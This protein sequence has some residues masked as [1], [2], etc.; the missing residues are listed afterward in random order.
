VE[1]LEEMMRLELQLDILDQPI[2]DHQRAKKRRLRLDI[3]GE[4]GLLGRRFAALIDSDYFGHGIE[5]IPNGRLPPSYRCRFSWR[6]L[7]K[8]TLSLRGAGGDV[9]IQQL[10]C[11]AALAMTIDGFPSRG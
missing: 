1:R 2:V 11:F 5:S 3:L 9:A 10:D 7:W 6:A 4:L 8:T